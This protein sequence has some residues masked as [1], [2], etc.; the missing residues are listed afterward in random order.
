MHPEV[1]YKAFLRVTDQTLD[2]SDKKQLKRVNDYVIMD[3]IM[4]LEKGGDP[5]F[6]ETVIEMQ[7]EPGGFGFTCSKYFDRDLVLI[8]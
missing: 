3:D 8:I 2:F 1:I 5:V 4:A 6:Y 7:Q